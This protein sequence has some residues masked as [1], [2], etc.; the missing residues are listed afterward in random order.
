MPDKAKISS[1]ER[2]YLIIKQLKATNSPITG[3]EFAKKTNVSRQVIVQDVSLL[4]AKGE[5]IVATSQGYI[6]LTQDTNEDLHQIV[7]VCR[8]KPEDTKEELYLIV[9]HGVTIKDV[10]VEHQVYG[11]LTAS[12][13][14]NNRKEVDQFVERIENTSAAYLSTLTDGIHLHT[15]EADSKEKLEAACKD[16]EKAGI[17]LSKEN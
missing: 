8:H 14:V 15:I 4:K 16:L 13:R 3:S 2:Q 6:Y 9:D 5:P 11:D 12:I 17:L 10:I 1:S 7:I